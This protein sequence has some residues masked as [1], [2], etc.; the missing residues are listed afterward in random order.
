[1]VIGSFGF[2]GCTVLT[3]ENRLREVSCPVDCGAGDAGLAEAAS[4]RDATASEDVDV[5][6]VDVSAADTPSMLDVHAEGPPDAPAVNLIVNGG[7]EQGCVAPWIS[8]Q[9]TLADSGVAHSGN[10][11][12]LVCLTPGFTDYSLDESNGG[13]VSTPRLGDTYLAEAW[14]RLPPNGSPQQ[15]MIHQRVWDPN[16]N[17]LANADSPA[18]VLTQSWQPISVTYTVGVSGGAWLNVYVSASQAVNGDC[19]LVDDVALYKQ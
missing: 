2:A 12:C 13:F 16:Y 7:F 1:V 14:V 18:A 11:A 8:W 17:A 4:E 10:N 15:S 9:G 6:V 19:F 3:G 5:M